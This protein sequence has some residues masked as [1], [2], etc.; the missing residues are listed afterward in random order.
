MKAWP[1][2]CS[3]FIGTALLVG[4]GCS[5]VILDFSPSSP[6]AAILPDAG[7]RRAITGFLFGSVGALIAVSP[8]GVVSGAHINP[9]VTLAFWLEGRMRGDVALGY[10][11]AQLGGGIV[12]AVPLRLWGVT[13]ADVAFGATAPGAAGLWVAVLGEAGATFCLIAGLLLFVGHPRM[14][15][16]TPVF[17]PFLYALLVWLEAPLSGASTNPAR[18]LGPGLIAGDLHAWWIFWVGP[19]LGTLAAIGLRR[20]LPMARS[21]EI[22]VAKVFHFHHDRYGIFTEK[23]APSQRSPSGQ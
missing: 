10:V 3:E 17:F 13:G 4:V 21:F 12:G 6:V 14:R 1:L 11:L 22:G 18:S 2:W 7:V 8:V 9:A 23:S 16:F 15:R 20:V 19:L 5:L